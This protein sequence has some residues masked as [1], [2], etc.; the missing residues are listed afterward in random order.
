MPPP[1]CPRTCAPRRSTHARVYG[2]IFPSGPCFP[3]EEWQETR[4]EVKPDK[5]GWGVGH[6]RRD[7]SFGR[8]IL[9][10]FAILFISYH[11]RYCYLNR[12]LSNNKYINRNTKWRSKVRQPTCSFSKLVGPSFPIIVASLLQRIDQINR[13]ETQNNTSG[14][15]L[16]ISTGNRTSRA[17]RPGIPEI[18]DAEIRCRDK[19]PCLRPTRHDQGTRTTKKRSG[20]QENPSRRRLSFLFVASG[21]R[22]RCWAGARQSWRR[23]TRG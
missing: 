4:A 21:P 7:H 20:G 5:K 19:Q 17:K 14:V 9:N 23:G 11:W 10:F 6:Y 1:A 2:G 8:P 3:D 15:E 16:R 13:I 12:Q 18:R 22:S